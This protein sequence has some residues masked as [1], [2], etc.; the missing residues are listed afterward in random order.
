MQ[1]LEKPFRLD[2]QPFKFNLSKI[3]NGHDLRSQNPPENQ[4]SKWTPPLLKFGE[5]K[6][7][8]NGH[9]NGHSSQ[10]GDPPKQP[11][12]Y[13]NCD[14]RYFNLD[15]LTQK[16]GQFDVILMNPVWSLTPKNL[17]NSSSQEIESLTNEEIL[18]LR[19]EKLSH[20]GFLFLWIPQAKLSFAYEAMARWGYEV[21]DQIIWVKLRNTNMYIAQAEFFLQSFE[22]CLVGYKCTQGEHVEYNSKISNNIIFSEAKKNN[23]KPN[24]LYEIIELMMPGAKKIELFAS[25]QNLRSGWFSLGHKLG[26]G[27]WTTTLECNECFKE[28]EKSV[29]RFKSKKIANYDI[30]ESCFQAKG[31][32]NKE[33]F[34]MGNYCIEDLPHQYHSCSNCKTFPIF[35]PRFQ[36]KTCLDYNICETCYDSTLQYP[37]NKIHDQKHEYE[38]FDY[39]ASTNS[40]QVHPDKKCFFCTQMP[41]LGVYYSCMSC[42]GFDICQNC[43]F[44]KPPEELKTFKGHKL[45]HNMEIMTDPSKEN[46]KLSYKCS[47]CDPTVPIQGA[48][49]K[50][51]QCFNFYFCEKC[52]F[53]RYAYRTATHCHNMG[54]TYTVVQTA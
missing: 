8:T 16:M 48:V 44:T 43:Y 31:L 37:E 41:I 51:D 24:E 39:P 10:N 7:E 26:Y 35:G 32:T 22:M 3:T 12:T 52:Y 20:K 13:I 6:P 45:F 11:P 14:L 38:A 29:R 50:C 54:H 30:C 18:N 5:P 47:W 46:N 28:I 21:V 34:E 19:I 40:N 49:Y 1:N 15:Y 2:S 9:A 42:T 4:I 36:C 23:L 33:F 25:N 27:K 17:P 53:K